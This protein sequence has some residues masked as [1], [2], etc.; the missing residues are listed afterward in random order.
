MAFSNLEEVL[1]MDLEFCCRDPNRYRKYDVTLETFE[2][3]LNNGGVIINPNLGPQ[4]SGKSFE[5]RMR[6][7]GMTLIVVTSSKIEARDGKLV[8]Q[9]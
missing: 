7:S 1:K 2:A 4:V 8:Y 3:A 9:D 5:Y 6:Y